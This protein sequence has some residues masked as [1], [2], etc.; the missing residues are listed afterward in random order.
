MVVGDA[1]PLR[2][3]E[4]TRDRGKITEHWDTIETIPSKDQW[5]NDNG[6]F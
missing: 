4:S 3:P 2:S 1:N 5:Q 6:K